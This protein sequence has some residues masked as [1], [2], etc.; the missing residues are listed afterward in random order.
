MNNFE[1]DMMKSYNESRTRIPDG[2]LDTTPFVTIL[3]S[4]SEVITSSEYKE[5][6]SLLLLRAISLCVKNYSTDTPEFDIDS[7]E[8]MGVLTALCFIATSILK[9]GEAANDDFA[10]LY[11]HYLI[12]S[13]L[14]EIT[15]NSAAVPYWDE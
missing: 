14:P 1:E 15:A 7:E 3:K 10:N 13:F 4:L 6:E 5:N 11:N 12:N 9:V 8:A 2:V